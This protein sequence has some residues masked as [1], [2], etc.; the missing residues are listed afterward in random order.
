MQRF[1]LA[2]RLD[3]SNN[4]LAELPDSGQLAFGLCETWSLEF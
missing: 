1:A 3:L 4:L 2:L